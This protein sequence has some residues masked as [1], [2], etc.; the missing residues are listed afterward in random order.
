[1]LPPVICTD[2]FSVLA[3]YE[4]LLMNN[5]ENYEGEI[6]NHLHTYHLCLYFD[7]QPSRL[8]FNI[9]T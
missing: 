3:N 9:C 7:V 5:T 8:C 6:E 2:S 1:M 4:L